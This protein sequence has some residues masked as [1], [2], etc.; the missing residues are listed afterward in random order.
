MS[1]IPDKNVER[2]REHITYKHINGS[3]HSSA[4]QSN[5]V[6]STPKPPKGDSPRV[7][8]KVKAN[9]IE[10]TMAELREIAQ[11]NCCG[12]NC[13]NHKEGYFTVNDVHYKAV[14]YKAV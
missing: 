13:F 3:L 1:P 12:I 7:E 8:E 14:D 9:F 10:I 2:N 11:Q 6:R 5:E 4:S